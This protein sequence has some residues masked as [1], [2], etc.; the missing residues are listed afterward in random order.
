MEFSLTIDTLSTRQK[1]L[2]SVTVQTM[3][4]YVF[5]NQFCIMLFAL[6]YLHVNVDAF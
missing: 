3:N 4:K 1:L 6:N 5:N 2:I